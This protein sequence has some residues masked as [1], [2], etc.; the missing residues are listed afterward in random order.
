[1]KSRFQKFEFE[2]TTHKDIAIRCVKILKDK[3]IEITK[4]VKQDLKDLVVY[5][6]PDIRSTINNIQKFTNGSSFKFNTSMLVN[7]QQEKLIDFLKEGKIK[8][9]RKECLGGTH[10]YDSLYRLLYDSVVNKRLTG[11]GLKG[12]QIIIMLAEY[13]FRHSMVTDS[14]INF[15]ACLI[16]IYNNILN[17][18]D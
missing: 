7:E 12:S 15:V 6:Y 9:I 5:F 2:G 10:D 14:E 13:Q 11:D 17:S 18:E 1:M 4:E 16:D 3:G 8:Q